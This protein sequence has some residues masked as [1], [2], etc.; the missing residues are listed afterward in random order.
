MTARRR[1]AGLA[2]FAVV[3]VAASLLTETHRD[4][5]AAGLVAG[6]AARPGQ[7]ARPRAEAAALDVDEWLARLKARGMNNAPSGAGLFGGT[8]WQPQPDPAASQQPAKPQTP[9]FP[10]V[11]LGR[12]TLGGTT[13]VVVS[14]GEVSYTA[15]VGQMIEQFRVDRIDEDGL[16]VTYVPN[17]ESRDYRYEQLYAAVSAA[18]PVSPM[19]PPPGADS[20]DAQPRQPAPSPSA[21]AEKP[22]AGGAA[23]GGVPAA[24]SSAV[25]GNAPFPFNPIVQGAAAPIGGMVFNPVP[26]GSG[27]VITPTAPGAAMAITPPQA[28]SGMVMTP[29]P[30]GIVMPGLSGVPTG[31]TAAP[32]P[33]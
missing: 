11:L 2:V 9:P 1:E 14:K 29:P 8:N 5:S 27:M 22:A 18:P 17:G 6:D 23:I 4:P 30:P 21:P 15:R 19:Q 12:M 16:R 33:Q 3:L 28:G 32:A 31:P 10:F 25:A 13:V 20:P 24:A 7:A 26:P